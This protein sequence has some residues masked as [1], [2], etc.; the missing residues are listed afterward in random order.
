[1]FLC[2]LC[3]KSIVCQGMPLHFFFYLTDLFLFEIFGSHMIRV[4]FYESCIQSCL[5]L[6]NKSIKLAIKYATSSEPSVHHYARHYQP[7]V[8]IANSLY[9]LIYRSSHEQYFA[10]D[11][12]RFFHVSVIVFF[13]YS[14][15]TQI[16]SI[17]TV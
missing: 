4:V 17:C 14:N 13:S 16:N 10:Q 2:C 11:L 8:S 1:M 15:H 6:D 12:L 5:K 3:F 7:L 9:L